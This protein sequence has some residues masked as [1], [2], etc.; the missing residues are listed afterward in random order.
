MY[1][2]G[3]FLPL[4][5]S[6]QLLMDKDFIVKRIKIAREEA[7]LTQAEL[8]KRMSKSLNTIQKIEN[9]SIKN[10]EKYLLKIS[11]ITK[12]PLS[13][14]FGEEDPKLTEAYQKAKILDDLVEALH[15]KGVSQRGDGS[16]MVKDINASDHANVTINNGEGAK[17]ELMEKIAKSNEEEVHV[18]K[19]V[20]ELEG[21]ERSLLEELLTLENE[22]R[23]DFAQLFQLMKKQK[24]QR[25]NINN[26]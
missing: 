11:N 5:D 8:S 7:G 26:D 2:F 22:E 4:T 24:G 15:E 3:I 1:G 17:K 13:Y 23:D 10:P 18:L 9:G 16:V 6:S 25:K 21:D 14:F 19:K 20:I 12:K